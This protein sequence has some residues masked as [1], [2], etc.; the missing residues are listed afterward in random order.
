MYICECCGTK[1]TIFT[2]VYCT[3]RCNKSDSDS[4][5]QS[6]SLSSLTALRACRWQKETRATRAA[7][8]SCCAVGCTN[9]FKTD[10]PIYSASCLPT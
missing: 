6:T 2:L 1:P 10:Y 9:P 5:Y 8:M 3:I 7:V 4:D